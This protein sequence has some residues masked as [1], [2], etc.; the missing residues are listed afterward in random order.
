MLETPKTPESPKSGEQESKRVLTPKQLS[1]SIYSAV[2][3]QKKGHYQADDAR[4][5]QWERNKKYLMCVW[6]GTVEDDVNV[7]TIRSNYQTKRP[8]LFFRNPKVSLVPTKPQ[9]TRDAVGNVVK[10]EQGL[11]VLLDNYVAA[12]IGSAKLNYELREIKFK[13]LMRKVTGDVLC[14]YGI[15]WAK[16]GYSRLSVGG[17]DNDRDTSYSYWIQR[18]DPRNL[19]YDWMATDIDN[20]RLIHERLILTRQEAEEYGIKLPD[21]YV[22]QLP[23]FL[24]DRSKSAKKQ[25]S[26]DDLVIV[27]ESY[28]LK[29]KKLY[30]TIAG[31]KEGATATEAKAS[32]D[33]PYP[34]EGSCYVPLVLNDDN[35]DIIGLSDVEPIEDQAKAI[36]ALR[37]KQTQ[38]VKWFGSHTIYEDGAIEP[39]EIDKTKVTDHGNYTKVNKGFLN[40]V[41]T[42]TTPS[43]GTD[44]YQMVN[45]HKEDIRT[46]LAIT[47]FQQ[48]STGAASTKATIG[49]IVQNAANNRVEESRDII[50]DFVIEC[51]RR[52]FAMIQKFSGDEE[53]LNLKDEVVDEDFVGVLKKEHGYDPKIPFLRMSR[54]DIQGEFNFEFNIED[55]IAQPKEVQAQQFTNYLTMVFSNPMIAQK[56]V[57]EFDLS[58]TLKKGAELVGID[59][60]ELKKGGPVM[61]SPEQENQMFLQGME[62]PEPHAK[63]HDDEHII[64]HGR[65]EKELESQLKSGMQQAQQM[66]QMQ[67]QLQAQQQEVAA[68]AGQVA[69]QAVQVAQM[70]GTVPSQPVQ[71]PEMP[72]EIQQQLDQLTEQM[73]PLQNILRK[74]KLHRQWHDM[75]RQKKEQSQSY[76]G[77]GGQQPQ[78]QPAASQQA[79]MQ[80]QAN[81][82]Q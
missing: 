10:N 27:W 51:V 15:G 50:K 62:V 12:R 47:E 59:L 79:A 41:R 67:Q 31:E 25:E 44:N 49:N 23:D 6:P 1:E 37:T 71:T 66:M 17:H 48:G 35:D 36:N 8:T 54:E 4:W 73:Q 24:K 33:D 18:V 69:E 7:N 34:F 81:S 2:K 57:E 16:V 53:Y 77:G 70:Q 14:P 19:V 52:L 39:S 9:F 20:V 40:M 43:M 63:D 32:V 22:C 28:D 13:K 75:S 56:F 29:N 60:G 72:P 11:P 5:K 42:E 30:W 26:D 80:G 64:S 21:G 58:K 45:E 61:L 38:H 3:W 76:G 82:A 65:L 68:Q 78:G 55:M 46:S 74:I